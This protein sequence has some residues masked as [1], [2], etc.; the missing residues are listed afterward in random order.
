MSVGYVLMLAAL[1]LLGAA[2]AR[3][4][5]TAFRA[6]GCG[7]YLFVSSATGFSVLRTDSGHGVKDGDALHG[8]VETIGHPILFDTTAGRSVFAQVAER[9]LTQ[10]EITQ[11]IAIRCRA[12]LGQSYSSGSVTRAAG[13]GSKIFVNTPQGYAVLQRVSGGVVADGDTLTGNFNRLGRVTVRDAQSG[14]NLVVFVEDLWLSA[15]AAA[16]KVAQSCVRQGSY[17]R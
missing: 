2:P 5:G 16:R 11:R 14:A 4:D 15:S 17:A 1:A 13:C 6:N 9:H 8:D 10:A 12:P 3:A 7:D